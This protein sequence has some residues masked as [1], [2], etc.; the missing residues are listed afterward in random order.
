MNSCTFCASYESLGD[1]ERN[2]KLILPTDTA[3]PHLLIAAMLHAARDG[4]RRGLTPSAVGGAL[5][6][7]L[8]AALDAL[9]ADELFR[10][11]FGDELVSVY[12]AIKRREVEAYEAS[13]TDWEWTLY[14]SAV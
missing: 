4:I 11:A 7:S 12:A 1:P 10:D 5:P 2:E 3:S 8:G 6:R 14:H 13:V 9:E